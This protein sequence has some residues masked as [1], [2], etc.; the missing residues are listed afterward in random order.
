MSVFEAI[1]SRTEEKKIL[2]KSAGK[3]LDPIRPLNCLNCLICSI[4][5]TWKKVVKLGQEQI[6]NLKSKKLPISFLA[7]LG[8]GA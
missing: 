3:L 6:L 2:C 4:V 8:P 1:A 5:F 7:Q